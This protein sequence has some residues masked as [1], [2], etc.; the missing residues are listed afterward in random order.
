M[1]DRGAVTEDTMTVAELTD[2]K[3]SFLSRYLLPGY[4]DY[5]IQADMRKT[6]GDNASYAYG[7]G[8]LAR[9]NA[10][11][12]SYYEFNIL[13]DGRYMIGKTV[14]GN[15]QK[16]VDYSI[17]STLNTGLNTWNTLRIDGVGNPCVSLP[18]MNC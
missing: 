18:M 15:F 4:S 9:C 16:L 13:E 6:Q 14:N 10:Q 17:S 2:L 8:L 3:N 5:S 11:G 12:N 7:Y 1:T